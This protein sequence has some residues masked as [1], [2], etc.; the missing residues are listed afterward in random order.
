MLMKRAEVMYPCLSPI[1]TMIARFSGTCLERT[2]FTV[3]FSIREKYFK[4][5][6]CTTQMAELRML[7]LYCINCISFAVRKN[8]T[9]MVEQT[10]YIRLSLYTDAIILWV[11]QFIHRWLNYRSKCDSLF[12]S[13]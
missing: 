4:S 7:R 9:T 11:S 12:C 8:K 13:E 6:L 3:D 10:T 2:A 5:K 1:P